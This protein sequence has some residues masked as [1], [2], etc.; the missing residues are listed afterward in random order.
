[1]KNPVTETMVRLDWRGKRIRIWWTHDHL[2]AS[3]IRELVTDHLEQWPAAEGRATM[4]TKN[5]A[6]WIGGFSEQ[7]AAVEVLCESGDGIVYYP[8]WK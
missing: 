2:I 4:P 6:K 1:M 8:D 5:I 7:V 3:R